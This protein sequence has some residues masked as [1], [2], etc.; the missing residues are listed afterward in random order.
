MKS[1]T[2]QANVINA[3]AE[4][5]KVVSQLRNALPVRRDLQFPLPAERIT[6]WHPAGEH[7]SHFINGL[8]LMFPVG[9]RFF[10]RSVRYYREQISNPELKEAVTGFIG[11]E[12]MHGREHEHYNQLLED[13]GL[14]ANELEQEVV[15]LLSWFEERYPAKAQLAGTIALEH[16]TAILADALLS[17][18]ELI[19]GAEPVYTALLRW[20][21]MEETEHKAVAFDVWREIANADVKHYLIRNIVM[22]QA[23]AL[24]LFMACKFVFRLVKADRKLTD[25]KGWYR[26]SQVLI[27][28]GSFF[29]AIAKPWLD[30]FR[31]GFHPWDH[32]NSHF[33]TELSELEAQWAPADRTT[34]KTA[35]EPRNKALAQ[36]A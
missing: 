32:D 6:N 7:M 5:A 36:A 2:Q 27:G 14:P 19:D 22:L 4:K 9:E 35:A 10:I 21:A 25:V 18:P 26:M 31:P 11:Q 28:K 20:H 16:F 3:N 15:S 13:A 30:Y 34:E 33:L 24:L 12:A 8:S 29:R 1:S 23:T 17:H